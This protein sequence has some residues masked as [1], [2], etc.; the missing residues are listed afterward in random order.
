MKWVDDWP[1]IG[2]DP[3]GDGIGEPVLE[4]KK[5]DVNKKSEIKIPQTSDDFNNSTLG[6]QWQ[7]HGNYYDD[8]YRLSEDNGNLRLYAQYNPSK[9]KNLWTVPNLLLQKF[10]A[11]D[12]TVTTKMNIEG[13]KNAEKSGLVIMGLDYATLTAKPNSKKTILTLATC[14]NAR[15]GNQEQVMKNV[16]LE[17]NTLWLRAAISKGGMCQFLYSIDGD[18]YQSIGEPFNSKEGRWIGAKVGIFSTKLE[19]TPLSGYVDFDYFRI[20]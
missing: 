20:D 12:F 11:P 7:W 15:E 6:L 1:V 17:T 5:P 9:S 2:I 19:Q 13:M 16:Q 14:L 3:D 8:W 18:S 4:F 10:P